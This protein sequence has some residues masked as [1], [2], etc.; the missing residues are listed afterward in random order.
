MR[1]LLG[2]FMLRRAMKLLPFWAV[3]GFVMAEKDY[4]DLP[5]I[6]D[7]HFTIHRVTKPKRPIKQ[8]T[9]IGLGG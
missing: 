8:P 2:W 9:F 3:V 5:E 7:D 4:T 1:E 6:E